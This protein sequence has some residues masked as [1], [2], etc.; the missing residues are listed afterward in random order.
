MNDSEELKRNLCDDGRCI[1]TINEKGFCNIC[2]EPKGTVRVRERSHLVNHEVSKGEGFFERTI[3][4]IEGVFGSTIKGIALFLAAIIALGVF[5][6]IVV[7]VFL[8][9]YKI[10][11]CAWS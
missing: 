10:A 4:G 7:T 1:G 6:F 9:I 11:K 3:S 2:G 8:V 5:L